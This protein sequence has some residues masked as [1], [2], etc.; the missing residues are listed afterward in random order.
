MTADAD[1][2]GL[3]PSPV[4]KLDV[5]VIRSTRR[6]KT[7]QARVL[8]DEL[9]IRIPSRLTK[10]EEAEMVEHFRAKFERVR[11]TDDLDLDV[12]AAALAEAYELPLPTSIRW[13][14]NQSHRWGS[15]TPS[16]GTIRISNRLIEFP[17]WVIDYVIVHELTHLLEHGHTT[18]FWEIVGRYPLAE[19]ARGF[20]IAKGWE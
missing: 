15:C 2:L 20:L 9:E 12:R 8:G 5:V 14:N 18:L 7:A 11:R 4:K 13:V 19:R 17:E 16:E 1:Q 6:R 10:A 3:E